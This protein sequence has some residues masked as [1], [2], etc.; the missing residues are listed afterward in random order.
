V[1]FVFASLGA[2]VTF[3]FVPEMKGRSAKEIDQMFDVRVPA[4][5]FKS[6]SD[7]ENDV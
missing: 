3:F 6:W 5:K 7:G 4:R 2:V 1:Y